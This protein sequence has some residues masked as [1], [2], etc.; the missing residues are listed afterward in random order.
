MCFHILQHVFSHFHVVFFHVQELLDQVL[1]FQSDAKEALDAETPDSSKLEL[2]IEFG[3]TLDVDL[4]EIPK[5][6]QVS[7]NMHCLALEITKRINYLE[8]TLSLV[9]LL[10]QNWVEKAFKS[11]NKF[12]VLRLST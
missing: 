6:K 3:S 7:R 8:D 4:P 11:R 12:M 1:N 5:L 9:C 10:P 2:L